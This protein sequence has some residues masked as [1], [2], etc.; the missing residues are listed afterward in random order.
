M[1]F[2]APGALRRKSKMGSP[3]VAFNDPNDT[4]PVGLEHDRCT[5]NWACRRSCRADSD[6]QARSWEARALLR[7]GRRGDEANGE[8]SMLTLE[9]MGV[10]RRCAFASR[11]DWW[12]SGRGLSRALVRRNLRLLQSKAVLRR[13][14]Y[15][16]LSLFAAD[17]ELLMVKTEVSNET[18]SA[19]IAAKRQAAE[20]WCLHTLAAGGKPWRYP[21]VP[22]VAVEENMPSSGLSAR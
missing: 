18:A 5:S 17:A 20:E 14:R 8:K 16:T 7:A 12:R 15:C 1:P 10:N 6:P 11:G 3:S 9:M 19:E 22:Q 4:Q 21:S 13:A 2:E